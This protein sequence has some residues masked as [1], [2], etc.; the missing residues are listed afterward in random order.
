MSD[1]VTEHHREEAHAEPP[2]LAAPDSEKLA[3]ELKDTY[4]KAKRNLLFAT[5][6]AIV[7]GFAGGATTKIPGLSDASLPIG[8][9]MFFIW[10]GC[11]YFFDDFYREFR[12]ARVSNSQFARRRLKLADNRPFALSRSAEA[13]FAELLAISHETLKSQFEMAKEGMGRLQH[14]V[15]VNTGLPGRVQRML[16]DFKRAEER[17]QRIGGVLANAEANGLEGEWG[18]LHHRLTST[19]AELRESL[20]ALHSSAALV[21]D[22]RRGLPALVKQVEQWTPPVS[23]Q[24]EQLIAAS[25]QRR[26]LSAQL[27]TELRRLDDGIHASQR[28][29]FSVRDRWLPL[30]MFATATALTLFH[31]W[32]WISP[33]VLGSPAWKG[34]FG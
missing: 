14:A 22:I 9:A 16:D 8:A 18:H 21:E 33:I 29:A 27:L 7:I 11:A 10:L 13:D 31:L 34:M 19:F 24:V 5:S 25:E 4:D 12:F 15:D 3:I 1:G 2:E 23:K 17:G 28:F 20:G 32:R 26:L 6:V 30:G